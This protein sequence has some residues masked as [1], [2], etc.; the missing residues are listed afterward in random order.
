M[1]WV[2]R[3]HPHTDRI[4][5]PWLIRKFIDPDAEIVYLR[6]DQVLEYAEHE[7]RS[8]RQIARRDPRPLGARAIE[9]RSGR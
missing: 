3:E 4:A 8:S 1:Q 7:R 6:R 2:T 5:C 9:S